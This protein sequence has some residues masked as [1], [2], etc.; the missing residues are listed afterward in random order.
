LS[1][2]FNPEW[3]GYT[4]AIFTTAAYIPQVVKAWREKHTS[5]ISLGMYLMSATGI[6]LWFGYGWLI[7]SSAILASN[8]V[9]LSLVL[10]I[11]YLKIKHG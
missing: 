8:L 3:I 7:N 11:I 10:S 9:T 2:S 5:S 1:A 4:A 6:V